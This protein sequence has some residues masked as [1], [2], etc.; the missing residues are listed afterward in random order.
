MK[1]EKT[2]MITE[3]VRIV[4][5]SHFMVFRS[6]RDKLLSLMIMLSLLPLVGISVFSYFVG[7]KQITEDRIK[8]ALE[9][10]AQDTA[11]KID[12]VL[13][14]QKQEVPSMANTVALYHSALAEQDR[15]NMIPLLNN[16]CINHEVYYDILAVVDMR[17]KIIAI[18]TIDRLG[19]PLSPTAYNQVMGEDISDYPGEKVLFDRSVRGESSYHDWYRSTL[20]Q[21]L[22]DYA[23]EDVSSQYNIAF[24]EPIRNPR[25]Q[26]I[27]GV[28]ISIINWSYIQSILDTVEIDFANQ[29]LKTGYA[30]MYA[31][32]VDTIIGHKYRQNRSG[33]EP[34][35]GYPDNLQSL[36]N[37]RIVEN[38][39][40]KN[41]HD[42]ILRQAH[43]WAYEFP[44]G[45][46]KISGIA[47]INDTSFGWIVGV[48]IDE[49]DIF[50]PIKNMTWW[51]S[52]ATVLL[53]ALVVIF[54]FIIAQG[55][56]VPLRNL[57]RTAQTIA[58]GNL[59][60]RVLI[61]SSDEVGILGTTFNDMARSL[62]AREEQLQ[63]LNRN[64][65][66]MVRQRTRELE[67]SHEALKQAYLDLQNTQE[68][69][70]QTEKMASLGQLV[71]GIAHEI[72]NPLNFIY[73]NTGFLSEYTRKLQALLDA[74]DSL[75]SLA[76]Q[77]RARIAEMKE[78][79][80]YNF[81]R[82][83]LPTLIDNFTE[84]A[85]R[86]NTIVS[87]LRTFSRLDSDTVAEIDVHAAIEISLNLLRNQ[88]RE[89]VE[90]HREY[91][92]IP[93]IQGYSGKLSQVFM[94]LISNAF[95]AISDKGDVWI[96]T[97]AEDGVV[98]VEIEDNGTGV[99]RENLKR[100]FEPFFTTKAVGQGTGLGLSIS[101]GIIE[102]H[103]GRIFVANSATGGAIFTVRLP[104]FLEKTA[105]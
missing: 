58:K 9:N 65:E 43:S 29:N 37:T 48:G 18:N 2:S 41:L 80:H 35:R 102:Q 8:L 19:K 100:I 12:I 24:S 54:T 85:S 81:I 63:E 97:R 86:I 14:G 7:S 96:R 46:R 94:N 62:A 79:F 57:I 30:F 5:G 72:K 82:E 60:Q 69:L 39:G 76:P 99:P 87:D 89:R 70:V 4:S 74:Y 49:T 23:N 20:V 61:R 104:I 64:L 15:W 34:L 91:G 42:A 3:K 78:G 52:G 44:V 1:P 38:H 10:K 93:K 56:T 66:D 101:Y 32:D 98:Q 33:V 6:L 45:N 90:I 22:Y 40:L 67:S 59:D 55:I 21:R 92:D 103:H 27:T 25:T 71:A 77:D 105:T 83:D 13:R 68:Q 47:A 50:R 88:Y 16:Y 95:H 51:L 75:P 73:G 84:G 31:K 26:E 53:A 17:G 11:D 28:W 36:Y